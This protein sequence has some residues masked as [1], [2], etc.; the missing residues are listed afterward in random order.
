MINPASP[1]IITAIL[2]N[3]HKITTHLQELSKTSNHPPADLMVVTK[4]QPAEYVIPLLE[5]G[6]RF[7]GENRVQ[8]ATLKWPN[9]K[10]KYP[11]IRLHLIG[12]LQRNKVNNAL[13]LFDGIEIIDQKK[14]IDSIVEQLQWAEAT[15]KQ[16]L[17]Q[18]NIGQEPQKSG[19]LPEDLSKLLDYAHENSLPVK[20]L[21]CIPPAGEDPTLFFK[22][23]KQL[24]IKH[25]LLQLSMGMSDDYPIA[26]A[27]G[28]SWI[29]VGS[30]IFNPL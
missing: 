7:F 30:S 28:S 8:E 5:A 21:M 16:F 24:A 15:P 19:V 1:E 9:L 22:Q 2:S 17:V 26:V 3:Y 13:N 14:L 11:D 4:N 29:R 12:P 6:H 18:V 27:L 25:N 10:K 23:F 20:G